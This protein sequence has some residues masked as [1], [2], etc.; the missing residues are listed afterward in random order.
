MQLFP[1]LFNQLDLF[2]MLLVGAVRK[3]EAGYIHAGFTHPGQSLFI[4]AGRADGT[5]D[6]GFSHNIRSFRLRQTA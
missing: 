5:Y 4:R 3:V 2:K 6:L 1:Y